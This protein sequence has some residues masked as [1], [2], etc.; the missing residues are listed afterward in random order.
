[1]AWALPLQSLI[2][3]MFPRHVHRPVRWRQFLHWWL[4]IVS[5]WQK[6]NPTK[7]AAK[8]INK[9]NKTP[10]PNLQT[11]AC[12]EHWW[13]WKSVWRCAREASS[14]L[15]FGGYRVPIYVLHLGL[16]LLKFV[17]AFTVEKGL[18]WLF[19]PLVETSTSLRVT[20]WAVSPFTKDVLFWEEG[21]PYVPQVGLLSISGSEC[22]VSRHLCAC[23]AV[24][25]WEFLTL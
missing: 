16:S 10:N 24:C 22:G 11:L 18:I 25:Q 19:Y 13:E 6:P 14:L 9:Q 12:M 15:S 8:Q 1:M 3:E 5:I 23:C 21:S 7:Q 17:S 4:F 2:K 20:A